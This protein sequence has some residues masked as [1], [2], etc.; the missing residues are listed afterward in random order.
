[1]ILDS[2][3]HVHSRANFVCYH[4]HP[5]CIAAPFPSNISNDAKSKLIVVAPQ[6]SLMTWMGACHEKRAVD[7][8]AKVLLA[9]ANIEHDCDGDRR[10]SH[11]ATNLVQKE[12]E[13]LFHSF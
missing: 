12:E 4:H 11:G 2:L 1:M 9:C 13:M 6:L 3:S 7:R 5:S 10:S 8:P